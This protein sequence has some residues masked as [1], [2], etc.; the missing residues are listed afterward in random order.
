[1]LVGGSW[2]LDEKFNDGP[3]GSRIISDTTYLD[4]QPAVEI[5]FFA[6]NFLQFINKIKD[7]IVA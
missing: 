4:I 7:F 2:L 3:M 5:D 6:F 1:L